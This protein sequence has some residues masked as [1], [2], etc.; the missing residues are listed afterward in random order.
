MA[1]F[2]VIVKIANLQINNLIAYKILANIIK[3]VKSVS[4]S[5]DQNDKKKLLTKARYA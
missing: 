5:V 3:G 1:F 2:L 4:K